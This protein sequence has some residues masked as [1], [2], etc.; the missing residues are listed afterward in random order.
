MIVSQLICSARDRRRRTGSRRTAVITGSTSGI[1]LGIAVACA[2]A[3]YDVMLHG[4]DA[5]SAMSEL[6][7]RLQSDHHVGIS[8]LA[9]DLSRADQ[10]DSFI[11]AAH[12]ELGSIDVLVNNAG[13]FHVERIEATSNID[14]DRM[15]AVNL[16][17][18]FKTTRAVVPEMRRRNHGRI[19]NIASSLALVGQIACSAYAASKHGVIGLTKC[20]ALETAEHGITVNALCPGYVRTPLVES[21]IKSMAAARGIDDDTAA[22]E[23]VAAVH[24]TARFVAPEEIGQLVVY[25]ASEYAASITGAALSMDGGWIA[26]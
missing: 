7:D 13:L 20:V 4:I 2:G 8:Y 9:A 10:I 1:G 14:W 5:P 18:V 15:M 11:A 22:A 25:L 24:P 16:T 12:R 6:M 26:K 3:G 23:I 19:I 21:E 17:A